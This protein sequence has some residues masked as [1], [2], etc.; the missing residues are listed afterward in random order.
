[1]FVRR[2]LCSLAAVAALLLNSVSGAVADDP[3]YLAVIQERAAK[4]EKAGDVQ[5]MIE[6]AY[7]LY[8][9]EFA[10]K[11]ENPRYSMLIKAAA[12]RAIQS[13]DP[14][15]A[16]MFHELVGPLAKDLSCQQHGELEQLATGKSSAQREEMNQQLAEE[17]SR[18]VKKYGPDLADPDVQLR[19]DSER[20]FCDAICRAALMFARPSASITMTPRMERHSVTMKGGEIHA[21]AHFYWKGAIFDTPYDS[22]V[23]VVFSVDPL[24]VTRVD[25]S[26]DCIT[27]CENCKQWFKFIR[28]V[29]D[30]LAK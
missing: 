4:A 1:M 20:E 28:E 7:A 11:A 10:A 5:A 25:Y 2:V 27:P 19:G 9:I 29:N 26:D 14:R 24:R 6:C 23:T 15:Q 8:P 12:E 18:P 3:A 16:Q 30:R 22:D 13:K 21:Y 17:G